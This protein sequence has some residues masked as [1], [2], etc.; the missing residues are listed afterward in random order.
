MN[1]RL[2]AAAQ[3]GDVQEL[4]AC[5]AAGADPNAAGRS[6]QAAIVRAAFAC[7]PACVAALLA[8]G[9]DPNRASLTG[10]TALHA[11]AAAGCADCAAT[12]LAAGAVPQP[13]ASGNRFTP[14][15]SAAMKGHASIAELLLA[16]APAAALAGDVAGRTPLDVA[17]CHNQLEAAACLLASGALPPS[18]VLPKLRQAGNAAQPLYAIPAARQVLT[19]AEWACVPAPCAGLGGALPAVL[20]RSAAEAGLLVQRLAAPDRVRLQC[21]ALCLA[22]AQRAHGAQL[23]T[24]LLWHILV[25]ALV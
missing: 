8:A 14:L 3:A 4:A 2:L 1:E 13:K 18:L 15:H 23:P 5:L 20:G 22:S 16:A 6:G 19:A 9:A 11:A 25:L 10:L 24:P 12:A 21:A 7:S 17:L